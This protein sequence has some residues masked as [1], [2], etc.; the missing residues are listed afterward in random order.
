MVA[1]AERADGRPRSASR[2]A[3]RPRSTPSASR[4]GRRAGRPVHFDGHYWCDYG[5]DP[6]RADELALQGRPRL[7][8]AGRHRQPPRRPRP[9]SSAADRVASAARCFDHG[10][11]AGRCRSAPRWATPP[12]AR[13]RRA[14][15]GGERGRRAP[16]PPPSPPAR[17]ARSRSRASRT[18]TPTR[19]ASTCSAENGAAS[20]DLT[21][22]AEFGFVD[23]APHRRNEGVPPG[24]RR[25]GAPVHHRRPADGLPRASATGR[26]TCSSSRRGRSST[27]WPASTGC[28]LPDLRAR[29]AQPAGPRRRRGPPPGGTE[30]SSRAQRQ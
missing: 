26:T 21:R 23:G 24:A 8:R 18:G 7:G 12:A 1:A 19:S 20:F 11:R 6:R 2:S 29:P 17:S 10:A 15:A 25:A 3:A 9:S 13:Q 22:P 5:C 30:R 28:R 4:S 14:R 16:S 27:R